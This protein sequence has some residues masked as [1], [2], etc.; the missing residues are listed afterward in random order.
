MEQGNKKESFVVKIG[1]ILKEILDRQIQ[2]IKKVTYDCVDS[3]YY[4]AGEIIG[5]KIND[6]GLV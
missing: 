4:E 6:K 1:P 5:K 3:S 2:K